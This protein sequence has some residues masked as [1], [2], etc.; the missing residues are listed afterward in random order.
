V[1]YALSGVLAVLLLIVILN[2][3]RKESGAS[4]PV[5][6]FSLN[7]P[8]STPLFW[9]QAQSGIAVAPDGRYFVYTAQISNTSQLFLHRMDQVSSQPI[10]GTE[11]GAEPAC[12][13]DGQWIVFNTDQEKLTKVSVLGG[14]TE[15]VTRTNGQTRG[16]WWDASNTIYFGHISSGIYAVPAKGGTPLLVTSLDS[17]AGEISHRY[18]QILP[19]GKTVLYTIK[20]NNITTFDDALIAVQRLGSSDRK[21]LVRGGTYARYIPTGYLM[22]VRGNMIYAAPFDADRLELTG[23][24]VPVDEGGW[25]NAASGQA[26]I[27][28]SNSGL[29]VLA[30]S[31]PISFS[32]FSL[33]WMD[34]QGKTTSL[35]DTM[36]AYFSARLSPDGQRIATDI[37]AANDDIW[38]YN[39]PRGTLTRLTFAGGNNNSPIW[40][41]DGKYLL[42]AAEK[43]KYPNIYRKAVDGSGTEVQLTNDANTK[44]PRSLTPDGK[45]MSFEQNGDIWIL[46]LDSSGKAYPLIQSPA[47]EHGGMFSPDG[48]FI[49]YTSDESGKSEVYVTAFPKRSGSW[50]VS[51]GGGIDPKWSPN[52]KE[53]FFTNG[54]VL[55]VAE[56]TP[57]STFDFSVP[58]KLCDI[59]ASMQVWDISPDG[60]RFLVRVVRAQENTMPRLEVVTEWFEHVREKITGNRH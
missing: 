21:I 6:R 33:A 48:R 5:I 31:G 27:A 17:T 53:L 24:P 52:G 16:I 25:M 19:D 45:M 37:N 51:S 14:A 39:I 7:L 10:P 3:P 35:L 12:S 2:S 50:Q 15:M 26:N 20:T 58:R 38:V 23:P 47:N 30:P 59:P 11:N 43:G 32:R 4:R 44:T 22:Y 54:S 36:R 18:P 28:F 60:K 49:A 41:S 29:L 40:S 13:P 9:S 1:G 42:Y 46:P 56:V 57:G 34:R 55:M 8:A